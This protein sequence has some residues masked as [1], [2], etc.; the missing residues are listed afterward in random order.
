MDIDINNGK[1]KQRLIK[2]EW[3][4]GALYSAGAI[5]FWTDGEPA[6]LSSFGADEMCVKN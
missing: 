1:D 5:E 3:E 6:S 2:K 4:Y